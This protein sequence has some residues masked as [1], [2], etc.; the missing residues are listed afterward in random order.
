MCLQITARVERRTWYVK[1]QYLGA[2]AAFYPD[3]GETAKEL[4]GDFYGEWVGTRHFDG[5]QI[6]ANEIAR[7]IEHRRLLLT[8]HPDS[9]L[10]EQPCYPCRLGDWGEYR[11]VTTA[12]VN[13]LSAETV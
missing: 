3:N 1:G 12:I 2:N 5:E 7:A 10:G 11:I 8:N 9:Q 4:T 6:V 13:R